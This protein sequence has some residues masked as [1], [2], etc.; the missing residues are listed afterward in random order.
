MPKG[1]VTAKTAS[2]PAPLGGWNARDSI[3]AMPETDAVTLINF[4]P[5]PTDVRLRFGYSRTTTTGFP[6]Q[7]PVDTIIPYNGSSKKLFAAQTNQIYDVTSNTAVS[8]N[9]VL[10]SDKFQYIQTSTVGGNFV[11]AINGADDAILYNGTN[12]IRT[13]KFTAGQTINSITVTGTVATVTTNANH[14]LFVNNQIILTG[15]TPSALNGAWIVASISSP[16]V[17][18]FNLPA[19]TTNAT[20]VGS[21]TVTGYTGVDSATLLNNTLF[22][23]RIWF[24]PKSGMTAYFTGVNAVTGDL[25]P[26]PLGSIFRKGGNLVAV[27]NWTIDGGS[28]VDDFLAFVTSEGELAIYQGTDPSTATSFALKGVW[29]LGSAFT[30]RCFSNYGGDLIALLSEGLVP[31]S[32]ALQSSRLDPRVNLTDKIYQAIANAVAD[33]SSVD[34]WQSIYFPGATMLLINVPQ[35]GGTQQYVMNT[36]SKAWAQFTGIQA[37]NFALWNDELYFG[38]D[39]FVGRYWAIPSDNGSNI[40]ANVQQAYSYFGERARTKRFT[41]ARPT[42]L[43]DAGLNNNEPGSKP[44]VVLDMNVDYALQNNLAP[45]TFNPALAAIGLWNPTAVP[46]GGAN[47]DS[48]AVWGSGQLEVSQEWQ[49]VSGIGFSAGLAMNVASQGIALRWVNT[50]YVFEPGAIL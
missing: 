36:I 7:N 45:A 43:I 44:G 46:A 28:G 47:W 15:A 1:R 10:T 19:T 29:M 49:S 18:T 2:L 17:F 31:L 35:L 24:T 13:A 38:G 33:Y 41:F 30:P 11:V 42:F 8:Q 21:Y 39:G 48:G 27:G 16:T 14:G 40:V 25:S 34:G 26:F 5:T 50:D 9:L 23:N 22:K 4:W 6:N 37:Y 20:V 3:A 32:S 12:W